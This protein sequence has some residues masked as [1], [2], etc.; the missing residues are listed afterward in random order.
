M[1]AIVRA[2]RGKARLRL[3]VSGP[4]KHGKSLSSLLMARGLN[5]WLAEQGEL[6][7]NPNQSGY[8]RI[9]VI[10]TE[11]ESSTKYAKV[12]ER[13]N[14]TDAVDFDLVDFKGPYSPENYI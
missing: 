7:G 5:K 1:A 6:P 9:C 11:H 2:R 14:R 4:P 10:D 13:D 12:N 3:C 8:G